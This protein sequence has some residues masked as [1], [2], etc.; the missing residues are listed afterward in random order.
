MTHTMP[1]RLSRALQALAGEGLPGRFV[2]AWLSLVAMGCVTVAG[3]RLPDISPAP[4]ADPPVIEHTVGDFS[5]H[6]DGGK[7]ITSVKAGR[8]VNGEILRRWKKSGFVASHKY[9]RSSEFSGKADYNLTLEGHQEGE[10]NIALQ[11][12]SGL[13]LFLIPYWVHQDH[14]LR[15]VLEH[16][17]TGRRFEATASDRYTSVVELLLAPVSPFFLGGAMRT[18]ERLGNHLYQQLADQDAFDSSSWPSEELPR[19]EP[20]AASGQ[21][22]IQGAEPKT[23]S[24]PIPEPAAARL[25]RLEALRAEGLISQ[26]EYERKRREILEDL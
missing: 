14:D 13:T 5:F 12:I 8:N 21:G 3:D 18:W 20:A 22:S 16:V 25:R 2:L 19:P 26:E 24:E 7:M 23:A 10:S 1:I 9:V 4:P 11:L 17:E 6:L 15:Y